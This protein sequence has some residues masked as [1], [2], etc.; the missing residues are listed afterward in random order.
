MVKCTRTL[1]LCWKFV[2]NST[3]QWPQCCLNWNMFQ[4]KGLYSVSVTFFSLPST[5]SLRCLESLP[6]TMLTQAA[7]NQI[8]S[9]SL[10]PCRHSLAKETLAKGGREMVHLTE[11]SSLKRTRNGVKIGKT[12]GSLLNEKMCDN[13][14]PQSMDQ[15]KWGRWNWNIISGLTAECRNLWK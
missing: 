8:F 10:Q 5:L 3:C 4:K 12:L 11:V 9:G 13:V 1:T 15:I 6:S 2:E 14:K 7:G